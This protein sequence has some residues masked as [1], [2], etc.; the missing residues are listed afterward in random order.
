MENTTCGEGTVQPISY[1]TNASNLNKTFYLKHT[2]VDDI[3]T[4]SYVEFVVT[5]EMA[6]A[7]SG[8]TAGTYYLK[9]GDNG[10]AY[11]TNKATLTTAFGSSNC[12]DNSSDFECSVSGLGA[13][14]RTNGDVYAIDDAGAGCSVRGGGNSSCSE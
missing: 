7:N 6:G 3:V 12:T 13:G 8:M 5:P 9:G 2:I 11:T 4:E 1:E 14:A 10:A